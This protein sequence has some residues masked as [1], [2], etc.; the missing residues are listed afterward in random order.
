MARQRKRRR[1][2]TE[3]GTDP[4]VDDLFYDQPA[5]AGAEPDQGADSGRGEPDQA[6]DSDRGEPDRPGQRPGEQSPDG[7]PSSG[8]VSEPVGDPDDSQEPETSEHGYAARGDRDDAGG[9]SAARTSRRRDGTRALGRWAR[10]VALTGV[11]AGLVW[12][13]GSGG[14]GTLDL[15]SALDREPAGTA[16]ALGASQPAGRAVLSER[17]VGCVGPGLVGLDDPSVTEPDQ[18]V[19]VHAGSA[20]AQAL[21]E[22]VPETGAQDIAL[23]GS[24]EG[25]SSRVTARD[26]VAT[27]PIDG[28][29]WARVTAQGPL[30]AGLAGSQLGY[31]FEAEQWGLATAACTPAQDDQWFIA[32]GDE[33]GRVERLILA[34]PTGNPVTVRVDMLGA[35]GPVDMVGGSGIVVA[36][37]SRQVVLLDALAPGETRPVVHVTSVGGPVVAALGDRWLEGT[38]DRGSEVTTVTAAPAEHLLIP[39]VPGPR[40]DTADT[41]AVRVGVPGEEGAVVQLRAL[42][43]DGPVRLEQGV[44]AIEPGAVVDI[45]VADLPEGTH[46]IEVSADA[47]VVAAGQVER[48]Q[49]AD[50]VGDRA[51]VPAVEPVGDLAGAPLA[52]SGDGAMQG[53]LSVSSLEGARVAVVIEAGGTVETTEV[54]IPAA[55]HRAIDLPA[56]T[57]GVWVRPLEGEVSA[58]VVTTLEHGLGTQIAGMP[59]PQAPLT[60]EVRAIAPALP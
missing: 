42:T 44:V 29:H 6:G 7:P 53:E 13:A 38:V 8:E 25:G 55:A 45:D 56:Q 23:A 31:S 16:D 22:E 9:A 27:L 30:A 60:R 11:A 5:T 18:G 24:P 47:A 46:A 41:A 50:D 59:L 10:T 40:A 1:G 35:Q 21:P 43:Q 34:N 3:P 54:D 33:A 20:P 58:A 39:A 32:G 51:W 48:R 36:P 28:A 52:T 19:V 26:E 12:V 14:V 4:K 37:G 49:S 57:E 2:Q 17:T 15:A